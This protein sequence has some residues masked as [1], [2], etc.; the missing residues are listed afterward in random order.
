M[1]I[2]FRA[3]EIFQFAIRLEENGER[4]YRYAVGI[5]EDDNTKKMFGYLADEEIKH[6]KIFENLLSRMEEY[7]PLESYPGEYWAYLRSYADKIIFTNEA[8][9]KEISEIKDTSSALHFGIQR[10]LDSLLYFHEMK[11]FVPES[12][13]KLIDKIID[14]ERNHF[15]QLSKLRKKTR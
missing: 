2:F 15:L 1:G 6:K 7:E 8:F 13:R 4:F 3:S 9:D 5:I 11:R 14:E 10:E 12:Q